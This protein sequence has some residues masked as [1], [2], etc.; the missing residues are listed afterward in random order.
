MLPRNP[1]VSRTGSASP[2]FCCAS[3]ILPSF[4]YF[5]SVLL[6]TTTRTSL[7]KLH[8]FQILSESKRRCSCG[9]HFF[10]RNARGQ[11][12]Q[13][14]ALCIHHLNKSEICNNP[15]HTAT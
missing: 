13:Y 9:A 12:S 7:L 15:R 1:I 2:K 11:F 6:Y 3:T 4:F 14:E 10:Y 5:F 8:R